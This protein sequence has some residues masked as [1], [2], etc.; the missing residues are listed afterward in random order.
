MPSQSGDKSPRLYLSGLDLFVAYRLVSFGNVKSQNLSDI[1]FNIEEPS[2]LAN[3]GKS[4]KSYIVNSIE[5]GSAYTGTF[6]PDY[7]YI[8]DNYPSTTDY[9][10]E[11]QDKSIWINLNNELES[12]TIFTLKFNGEMIGRTPK[13]L[14]FKIPDTGRASLNLLLS[15]TIKDNELVTEELTIE[16]IAIHK[17]GYPSYYETFSPY[18]THHVNKIPILNVN[19]SAPGW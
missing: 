10:E 2:V 18:V 11:Q 16:K 12:R 7:E 5:L 19:G 17:S 1:V 4:Y 6:Y 14:K 3:A 8:R 15:S 13:I 9:Y